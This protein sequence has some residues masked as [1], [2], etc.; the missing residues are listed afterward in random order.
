VYNIGV[1]KTMPAWLSDAKK[2]A[3]R[4]DDEFR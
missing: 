2:R 1:G 3:L 4:K